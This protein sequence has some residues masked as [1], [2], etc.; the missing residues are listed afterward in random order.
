[1]LLSHRSSI[2][3]YPTL[4]I[5][6]LKRQKRREN[7]RMSIFKTKKLELEIKEYR[8][9]DRPKLQYSEARECLRP[10]R[11]GQAVAAAVVHQ[12]TL[13]PRR[14]HHLQGKVLGF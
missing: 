7:V 2:I 4:L 3:Y 8:L 11:Q 5:G 9:Q 6:R 13:D 12:V 1:M 14:E 10:G